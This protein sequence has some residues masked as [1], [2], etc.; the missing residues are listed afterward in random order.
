M[1]PGWLARQFN[2]VEQEV[3]DAPDWMYDMTNKPTDDGFEAWLDQR[4]TVVYDRPTLQAAWKAATK[5]ATVAE[6][7]R[8]LN[9][10][11]RHPHDCKCDSAYD[12]PR[13][14]INA[15]RGGGE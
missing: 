10:V 13:T 15:I 14:I 11:K 5:Q 4:D 12:C 3:R 1:N 7:A 6:W 8:W 9:E 2:A